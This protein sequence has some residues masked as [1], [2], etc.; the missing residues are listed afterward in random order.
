MDLLAQLIWRQNTNEARNYAYY[1]GRKNE[2][3]DSEH[4]D[5]GKDHL[6]RYVA[7]ESDEARARAG[8]PPPSLLS[9]FHSQPK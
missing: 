9:K 2:A 6:R 3:Q 5:E 4:N 7:H 1:R 8:L